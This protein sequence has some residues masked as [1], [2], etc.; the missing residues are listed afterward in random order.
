MVTNL[1][2]KSN[3]IH[4]ISAHPSATI[5]SG[6]GNH[7]CLGLARMDRMPELGREY[8]W[9]S[10]EVGVIHVTVLGHSPHPT[11]PGNAAAIT[12]LCRV[13]FENRTAWVAISELIGGCPA[14]GRRVDVVELAEIC[15]AYGRWLVEFVRTLELWGQGTLQPVDSIALHCVSRF[16]APAVQIDVDCANAALTLVPDAVPA[17]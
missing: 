4:R 5:Q 10:P 6:Q 16:W 15:R 12:G 9:H 2:P 7:F 1:R 14:G 11:S 3:S 13:R 8:D 17:D